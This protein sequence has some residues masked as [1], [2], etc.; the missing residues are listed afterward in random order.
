[1]ERGP[2]AADHDHRALGMAGCSREVDVAIMADEPTRLEV[3]EFITNLNAFTKRQPHILGRTAPSD[4]DR[5][6]QRLDK[7]LGIWEQARELSL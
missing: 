6:H 1:M 2:L 3:E 5:A 7:A 4:W